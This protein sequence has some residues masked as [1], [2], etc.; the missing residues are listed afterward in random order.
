MDSFL[1]E[2]KRLGRIAGASEMSSKFHF[3]T[4]IPT[5]VMERLRSTPKIH[6]LP[7]T[8]VL[9]MARAMVQMSEEKKEAAAVMVAAEEVEKEAAA[10]AAMKQKSKRGCFECGLDHLVRNCPD[11][12][13]ESRSGQWAA[14]EHGNARPAWSWRPGRPVGFPSD[15]AGGDCN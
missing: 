8:K 1:N 9:D 2:L 3:I 12:K 4:G 6:E 11:V 15:T 7:Q 13:N 10:V 14:L 5:D